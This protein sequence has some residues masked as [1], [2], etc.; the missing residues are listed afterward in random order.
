MIAGLL[1]ASLGLFYAANAQAFGIWLGRLTL[2][3]GRPLLPVFEPY[4]PEAL[5]K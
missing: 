2:R 5:K 3:S 1:V 4:L